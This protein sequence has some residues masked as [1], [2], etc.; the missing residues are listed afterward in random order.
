MELEPFVADQIWLL[1]YRVRYFGMDFD[2][3]M[4][5]LRLDGE[6]ILIHSP[7]PM[8][9]A[10]VEA[11]GRLGEVVGIIAPGSFHWF[12]V[13]AAQAAFPAAQVH[14]CPGVEQRL[15]Q[16][17]ADA[18]LGVE[19]PALW[20]GVLDQVPVLSTRWIQEVAFFHRPTRSLILTDLV[21]W[22]GD[23]TP[24][25]PSL[26]RVWWAVLRMWNKP[27][28]APEYQFGWGPRAEVR[29]QL[30]KILEWKAER[31]VIAHGDLVEAD[32]ELRLR[33]AWARVLKP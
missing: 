20:S 2:A 7:A 11:I 6:R 8:E 15:P 17:R 24:R 30:E 3:R 14:I 9:A 12:H 28:P 19:A 1:A 18:V 32:V 27:R 29:S 26:M 22:V 31:A 23:E 25:V 4:T 13:P 33:D 10:T 5:V 21:E 16:L